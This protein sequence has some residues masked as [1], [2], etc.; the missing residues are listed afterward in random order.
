[1]VVFEFLKLKTFLSSFSLVL[2]VAVN[3]MHQQDWVGVG[4]EGV[5]EQ[6]LDLLCFFL[7]SIGFR[8]F[9]IILTFFF[10]IQL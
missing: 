4:R 6:A 9:I 7:T 5:H 10:S 1:M 3:I 8:T 2:A